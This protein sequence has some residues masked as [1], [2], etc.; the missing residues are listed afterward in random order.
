MT[1]DRTDAMASIGILSI[2]LGALGAG[3]ALWRLP[4]GFE[5]AG[6]AAV[7]LIAIAAWTSL[8]VAGA[9]VLGLKPWA[10]WLSILGG[11]AVAAVSGIALVRGFDIVELLFLAYGLLSASMFFLPSWREAFT[12]HEPILFPDRQVKSEEERIRTAA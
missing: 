2:T 11:L 8:V 3:A 1:R 4:D 12:I 9:G 10:R 5:D 6:N 7:S